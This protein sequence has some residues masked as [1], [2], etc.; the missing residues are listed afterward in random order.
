MR[1]YWLSFAAVV[2]CHA[3]LGHATESSSPREQART[4]FESGLRHAREGQYQNSLAD[5]QQAHELVPHHSVLFNIA[6]AHEELGHVQ[7]AIEHY[8]R[9]LD[10]GRGLIPEIRRAE[11]ARRL[12][13]LRT[14]QRQADAEVTA[15][16]HPPSHP[17]MVDCPQPAF[18]LLRGDQLLGVTPLSG[19]IFLEEGVHT[20]RIV[21]PDHAPQLETLIIT[22]GREAP[23]L[24]CL[25]LPME[26]RDTGHRNSEIEKVVQSTEIEASTGRR[27]AAFFLGSVGV[28]ALSVSLAL[29][30]WNDQK[31]REWQRR[32][33]SIAQRAPDDP[34]LPRLQVTSNA[35]LDSIQQF[36]TVTAI[37]AATGGV[38]ILGG[39]TFA[40][41][42]WSASS[43]PSQFATIIPSGV[44]YRAHW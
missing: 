5:F 40:L 22:P 25:S 14:R 3:T 31:H 12:G 10:A 27:D 29:Y 21:R 24:R 20:I 43:S 36:D 13:E 9:Y 1:T 4:L 11:V 39:L 28:T 8:E 19:R 32:R 30:I 38:L 17:V 2:L 18:R 42:P 15:G 34:E 41:L 7:E 35:E 16:P 26:A 23:V 33:D 37:T 6:R 44:S